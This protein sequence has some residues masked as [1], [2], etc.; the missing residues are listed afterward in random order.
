MALLDQILPHPPLALLQQVDGIEEMRAR[1]ARRGPAGRPIVGDRR[2][3]LGWSFQEQES[4]RGERRMGEALQLPQRRPR[5]PA[6]PLPELREPAEEMFDT[7]AR[8]LARPAQQGRV[9]FDAVHILIF[10]GSA[11]PFHPFRVPASTPG[12]RCS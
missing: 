2:G 12:Y 5:S 1:T 9:D 7:E 3:F 8:A 11:R 6:F 4:E 10:A